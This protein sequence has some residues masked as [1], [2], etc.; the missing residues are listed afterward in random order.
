MAAV[1]D[2]EEEPPISNRN[3]TP[4]LHTPTLIV[5]ADPVGL[6]AALLLSRYSVPFRI[7]E[8]R[9]TAGLPPSKTV[10]CLLLFHT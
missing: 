7:I 2:L 6:T 4:V 8:V 10:D 9:P 5:G 1:L 3:H